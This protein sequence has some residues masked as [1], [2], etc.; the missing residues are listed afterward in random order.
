M[1]FKGSEGHYQV[2]FH[3]TDAW[4]GRIDV[5]IGKHEMT[6]QV[7]NAEREA[8]GG[9]I[10]GGMTNGSSDLWGDLFWFELR[11]DDSPPVIRYWGDRVVW[12]EDTAVES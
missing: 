4:D 12:R 3:P 5:S 2:A 9:L 8:G 7:M 6:W 1:S 11:L 10:L